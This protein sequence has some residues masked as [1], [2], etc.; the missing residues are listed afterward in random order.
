MLRRADDIRPYG[1]LNRF[2]L[3]LLIW[4]QVFIGGSI[5]SYLYRGNRLRWGLRAP[6]P[7][8]GPEALDPLLANLLGRNNEICS[9]CYIGATESLR[10]SGP[11]KPGK[12]RGGKQAF[13]YGF[14]P[15]F[16]RMQS[17]RV[18]RLSAAGPEAQRRQV[19]LPRFLQ[20]TAGTTLSLPTEQYPQLRV[21]GGH[22][23]GGAWGKTPG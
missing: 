4:I 12:I 5:R 15:G 2:V 10:A 21:Q 23:P 22:H 8:P 3:A 18:W 20:A 1:F 11:R 14:F 7:A 13:P 9:A 17:I 6:R 16:P 19:W